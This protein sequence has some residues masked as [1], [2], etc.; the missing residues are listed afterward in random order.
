MI[1]RFFSSVSQAH[2]D[3]PS[4]LQSVATISSTFPKESSSTYAGARRIKKAKAVKSPF[5]MQRVPYAPFYRW[6]LGYSKEQFDQIDRWIAEASFHLSRSE[7]GE[8]TDRYGKKYSWIAYFEVAGMRADRSV[9]PHYDEEHRVSNCDIDPSFPE[10]A[11]NWRPPHKPYFRRAARSPVRW[12]RNGNAPSYEHILQLQEVDGFQGPWVVLNGFIQE[13]TPKDHREVFTF[14]R[15]LLVDNR[16]VRRLRSK[17]YSIDYPGNSAIPDVGTEHY[18]FA[19][20]V[21]WSR[22]FGAHLRTK[23]GCARRDVQ[24]AFEGSRI[25]KVRKRTNS[26]NPRELREFAIQQRQSPWVQN[27]LNSLN[28]DGE[29]AD[30]SI[31]VVPEFAEF[32][33]Y[34]K[35]P[36]IRFEMPVSS[37]GWESYHSKEN[38]AGSIGY[39][40]P[41]LCE[42]LGL[43][44]TGH[45]VDLVDTRGKPATLYRVFDSDSS[46]GGSHLLF[47]RKDLLKTYLKRTNQRLAWLLW[48]ERSMHYSYI[49]QMRDQLQ[50]VWGKRKKK[51]S[52]KPKRKKAAAK[53]KK[54]AAAKPKRKKAVAKPKKR[55]PAAKKATRKKTARKKR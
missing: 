5:L 14:V 2:S 9:L 22:T 29:S 32:T 36:G 50:S 19:G 47:L 10:P 20:E 41:A 17:F 51:A 49:E 16:D 43:R 28:G 55:K 54:K 34:E 45:M 27:L 33:Q 26:L 3:A 7:N 18:V 13:S 8:K 12:I 23:A 39:P 46:L 42:V 15:G 1:V 30:Q 48:G 25:N 52:A 40:A 44:N 37:F 6:R 38:Q 35:V 21:P 11:P 4:S 31:A 24:E 53:P